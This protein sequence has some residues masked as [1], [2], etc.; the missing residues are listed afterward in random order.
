LHIHLFVKVAI[1]DEYLHFCN[2]IVHFLTA[3]RT[4]L[5]SV[6][7]I[8]SLE[9]IKS[10]VESHVVVAEFAL[11]RLLQLLH[12]IHKFVSFLVVKVATCR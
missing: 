6:S 10:G 4:H 9:L 12:L 7:L 2:V 11:M 3:S 1:L 8:V 5:L